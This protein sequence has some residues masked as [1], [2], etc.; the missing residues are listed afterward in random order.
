MIVGGSAVGM[1]LLVASLL[2]FSFTAKIANSLSSRYSQALAQSASEHSAAVISEVQA[3]VATMANAIAANYVSGFRD[4]ASM[5]R[6]ITPNALS[7]KAVMASWFLSAPNALDGRDDAMKGRADLG[8]GAKGVFIP[9]VVHTAGGTRLDLLDSEDV[10]AASY[11]TESAKTRR[12]AIVEPYLYAVGGKDVAMTSITSPVVVN[13]TFVGVAGM[14]MALSDLTADLSALKPF[15]DG[16][17]MLLSHALNWAANPDTSLQ[18]KAYQDPGRATIEAALQNGNEVTIAGV[19]DGRGSIERFVMPVQLPALGTSWGV[20]LD[21]PRATVEAPVRNLAI[22][23]ASGGLLILIAVLAALLFAARALVRRPLAALVQSVEA[24]GRGHYDEPVKGTESGDEIGAVARALDGF[25]HELAETQRLRSD[26]ETTRLRSEQDRRVNEDT[27]AQAAREQAAVVG[28]VALGLD[29]L[30]KGDLTFRLNDEFGADYEVLRADFNKAMSELQETMKVITRA[31]GEIDSGTGEISQASNDL[32][33][34]T[35]SQ[36]ASLEETA[37]ALD[38]IT[39]TVK[40]TAANAAHAKQTVATAKSDA[41]QSGKVV[42]DAV[43]A[44]TEIEKSSQQ[45]SRI[46]GVI[47]EIAFQTNLLALNAGVEAA[48]AGEAGRGFA[49]VASEVR[50]LAQ[51]SAEAAKEI[52]G[53]IETSSTHVGQGASLVGH[54]GRALERIVAQIG[55]INAVV[56]TIAASAQEQATG[57]TEVNTAVNQMDQ[58]TQQ[59]AA[60]VEQSTAASQNLAREAENLARLIGRFQIGGAAEKQ[61]TRYEPQKVAPHAPGPAGGKTVPRVSAALSALKIVGRGGA[62]R[63][64]APAAAE[65]QGWEEF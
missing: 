59:N 33:R 27:R 12:P 18:T 4:R 57:L 44:M 1:L 41:E 51:R 7:S 21:A 55:E 34:R 39:A 38:E 47:D 8:S 35:E 49:V 61:T 19:E 54:T 60:M 56:G 31:A 30:S 24:L 10:T 48:R 16:Q 26:Q 58:V 3:R 32:S 2:V 23:M 9:Y 13:G 29:K 45:I 52:K 46:I 63:K 37:A 43:A 22:A 53:L 64:A 15:G 50:G 11:T 28:S 42:R 14:D 40:K 25:R 5:L 6:L 65:Q 36:A 62:V 17:V 20:V